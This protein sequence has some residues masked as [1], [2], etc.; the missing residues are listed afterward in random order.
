MG[1]FGSNT[2]TYAGALVAGAILLMVGV[3]VLF[4]GNVHF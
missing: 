3:A 2:P 4:R 1:N